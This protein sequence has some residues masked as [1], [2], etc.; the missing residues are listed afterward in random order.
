MSNQETSFIKH[1][2][3]GNLE[4]LKKLISDGFDPNSI[5]NKG[6]TPIY[7]AIKKGD[8]SIV[9]LL[10]DS[11]ANLNI[12]F[13]DYNTPLIFAIEKDDIVICELLLKYGANINEQNSV[14]ATPLYIASSYG[15][16]S[17]V[18]LLISHG[19]DVNLPGVSNKTP[20]DIAIWEGN[21]NIEAFLKKNGAKTKKELGL[22]K[23]KIHTGSYKIYC[24]N[25]GN[26]VSEDNSFCPKCGTKI[27]NNLEEPT[28]AKDESS[29]PPIQLKESD[30][31]KGK[32]GI[33]FLIIGV[34]LFFLAISQTPTGGRPTPPTFFVLSL[35]VAFSITISYVSFL[36]RS[37]EKRRGIFINILELAKRNTVPSII[38]IILVLLSIKFPLWLITFPIFYFLIKKT[39]Q[40]T[41]FDEISTSS[42]VSVSST[43]TKKD[44]SMGLITI[45]VIIFVIG[46]IAILM[47]GEITV[48]IVGRSHIFQDAL[49]G[50]G[51]TGE[52]LTVIMVV[53]AI[54]MILGLILFVKGVIQ[55]TSN[56]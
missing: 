12:K 13:K 51:S 49:F 26:K 29:T 6:N 17:M 19:A 25:C 15:N 28:R 41:S 53:S 10:L 31:S 24:S 7:Y 2:K 50:G 5:D 44:N 30:S 32:V 20:L 38:F 43:F 1:I 3:N 8:K 21:F 47:R 56:K 45:G 34:M 33:I 14:K 11:G 40:R 22:K 9:K 42:T 35:V 18:K 54:A 52:T 39:V 36:I 55:A 27:I 16:I 48:K 4:E 46:F 23:L 37:Q